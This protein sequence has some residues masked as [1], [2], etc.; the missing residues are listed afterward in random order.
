MIELEIRLKGENEPISS[1]I[2]STR[3][4]LEDIETKLKDVLGKISKSV[5][6]GR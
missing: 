5:E 6:A 3:C 4:G 1:Y 2:F